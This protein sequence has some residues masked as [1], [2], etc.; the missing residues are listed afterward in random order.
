MQFSFLCGNHTLPTERKGGSVCGWGPL[1]PRGLLG[2]GRGEARAALRS[3]RCETTQRYLWRLELLVSSYCSPL[4][5]LS[6]WNLSLSSPFSLN[7][8]LWYSEKRPNYSKHLCCVII[9]LFMLSSLESRDVKRPNPT[10]LTTHRASKETL[11]S[12]CSLLLCFWV[13]RQLYVSPGLKPF[14]AVAYSLGIPH[15]WTKSWPLFQTLEC[16]WW[17]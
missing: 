11:L 2:R 9:S 10:A 8:S 4:L 3:V 1:A 6:K 7:F 12:Q 15:G 5:S 14:P 13:P 16:Q 17:K